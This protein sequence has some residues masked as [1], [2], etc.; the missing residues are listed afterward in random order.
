MEMKMIAEGYFSAKQLFLLNQEKAQAE[1]PI[2]QSVY[3]VIY[4]KANPKDTFESL[5]KKLS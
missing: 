5:S 2:L 4:Q 3:A 1:M